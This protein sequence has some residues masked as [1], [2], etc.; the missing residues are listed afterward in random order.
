MK[1]NA[2]KIRAA[3]GT[4]H[5]Q[6]N[7]RNSLKIVNLFDEMYDDENVQ[8]VPL[9]FSKISWRV[10]KKFFYFHVSLLILL[11]LLFLIFNY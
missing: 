5:E 1:N 3:A 8:N 4:S 7:L 11:Y 2:R 10:L 9:K 6:L